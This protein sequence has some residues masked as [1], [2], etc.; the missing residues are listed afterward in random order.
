MTTHPAVVTVA[1]RAPL[2]IHQVVTPT[3]TGNEVLFL[4]Q[5][6]ASTPLDLHQADAH[7]L[8]TP[9]QALGDGTAGTVIACGPSVQRLKVGDKVFGFLWSSQ[10]EKAHQHYVCAPENKLGKLPDG[11]RME[12]AVTLPSGFVTAFHAL[13]TDLGLTLPWP[14]PDGWDPEGKDRVLLVWG[15]SSSVGQFALQVLRYYGFQNVIAT[16]SERNYE[17]VKG[18]GASEVFDY[19]GSGGSNGGDVGEMIKAKVGR[20]DLVFDCIGSLEG[21]VKPISRIV[22]KGAKVAVLLPV[23]LRDST[24]EQEPEYTLDAQAAA[25]WEEGVEVRGV[26]THFYLDNS[27]N[28]EHLQPD[29]MPAMLAQGI[30]KPNRQRIVE[31]PTLLARAQRA[32]DMLRRKEIS[33]ERLVWKVAD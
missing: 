18:C 32:V 15:G 24:E 12:E 31:G 30:V 8:V 13:G 3:P 9:P 5:W 7:L 11:V 33:G 22:G 2:E 29:I 23:V 20:V 28:A 25:K 16:A 19:R 6:T 1:K 26:R 17:L 10:K 27:F 4:S 21:S 14:K